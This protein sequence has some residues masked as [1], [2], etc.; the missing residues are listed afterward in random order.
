MG[1][2]RSGR[3]RGRGICIGLRG[4]WVLRGGVL[5]C[6]LDTV[7]RRGGDLRLR[8]AKNGG[9]GGS[10]E[11]LS[12]VGGEGGARGGGEGEGRGEEGE[13]EEDEDGDG[14]GEEEVSSASVA[15]DLARPGTV[16]ACFPARPD[17]KQQGGV[18]CTLRAPQTRLRP[19]PIARIAMSRTLWGGRIARGSQLL[20]VVLPAVCRTLVMDRRRVRARNLSTT[21]PHPP[22]RN[23]PSTHIYHQFHPHPPPSAA[24][25]S[26]PRALRPQC[27]AA[28]AP[29]PGP[30]PPPPTQLPPAASPSA[31]SGPAPENPPPPLVPPSMV[32]PPMV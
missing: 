10:T 25:H 27:P 23:D 21:P 1:R 13:G 18:D 17:I 22:A 7:E 15:I 8:Y 9:G 31:L 24:R 32:Q 14:E 3:A 6:R 11:T 5:D 28:P 30:W 16:G 12:V 20:A 19:I 29:H 4:R 2:S 26:P